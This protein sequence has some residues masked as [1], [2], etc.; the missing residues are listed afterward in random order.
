[1]DATHVALQKPTELSKQ[2][3]QKK[4]IIAGSKPANLPLSKLIKKE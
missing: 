3:K 1:V 2:L 4:Y